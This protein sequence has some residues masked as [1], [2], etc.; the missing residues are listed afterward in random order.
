MT[1]GAPEL[2]VTSQKAALGDSVLEVDRLTVSFAVTVALG[3][4]YLG[5]LLM[6]SLMILPATVAKRLAGSIDG[7]FAIAVGA[8]LASTLLRTCAPG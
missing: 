2:R 6:G 1:T 8:A 7:M 4:R 3:M 5:A